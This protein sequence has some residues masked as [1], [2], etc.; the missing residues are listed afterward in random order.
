[1]DPS[2]VPGL[3]RLPTHLSGFDLILGG[4]LLAG[5]AYLI[6]GKPG[7]GKTTL[8]NH[9]AYAHAAAG[10]NVLIA[11]LL[12][13][14]HER[15]L[16]HLQGLDFADFS[17]VG[18]SVQYVSLVGLLQE[19]DLEGTIRALLETVQ[20]YESTLLIVDGAGATQMPA[21]SDFDYA[22]FIH[23]LHAR[24]TQ[25]G[26][27]TVF[28]ASG[29]EADAATP[30]VDGVLHLSLGSLESRDTRWLRVTKLRGSAYLSGWH[31]FA[32]DGHG[33]TVFPRLESMYTTRKPA[34]QNPAERVAFGVAGLDA[35]IA[36]G[37]GAGSSTMVLGTPGAGK[38]VASLHFLAEGA[39]LG[40]PG[41][42]AS[43]QETPNG[44]ASTAD[45]AGMDLGLHLESGLVRVLWRS[46]LE[47]TP[48]AWA[49]EFLAAVDT[50]RPR[51]VVIDAF[52][53]LT[54]LFAVP[55]RQSRFSIALANALRDRG[56]TSLFLLEIDA[57]TGPELAMPVPNLSA[58]MDNGILL[59]SVE[60]R[61]SLH[62][63]VSIL[64]VREAGF[65]PTMREFTIGTDGITVGEPFEATALLTG[66]AIDHSRTT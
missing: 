49:W 20:N 26:C 64:K 63:M 45:R 19:G 62:R 2:A 18:I 54:K 33:V 47:L 48:D 52:S 55:D 28:L 13:E 43:F 16:G 42:I 27:T 46:P 24:A 35:M 10:G 40:E 44:L 38:T 59:R 11:T 66:T 30:H 37:L 21:R 29:R 58:S 41:L 25:L 12:T 17:L 65:D 9:L 34:W 4:G 6:H 22:R 39:R 51:R 36:G 56:V 1:M 15:M 50:Y 60:L 57:L 3:R 14:T 8:G 61:S 5:D 23:G 32:I 53:D 31:D 7:T